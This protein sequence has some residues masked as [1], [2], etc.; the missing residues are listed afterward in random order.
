[1]KALTFIMYFVAILDLIEANWR[2]IRSHGF[3]R[4]DKSKFKSLART[5]MLRAGADHEKIAF[6]QRKVDQ[7]WGGGGLFDCSCIIGNFASSIIS[8]FS[9]TIRKGNEKIKCFGI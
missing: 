2:V 9:I 1:M 8:R 7:M 3:T 4:N 5:A 6:L